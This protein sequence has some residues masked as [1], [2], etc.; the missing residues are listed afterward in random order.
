MRQTLLIS[1]Y[2]IALVILL[3]PGLIYRGTAKLYKWALDPLFSCYSQLTSTKPSRE[4]EKSAKREG[5]LWKLSGK[6]IP[7]FK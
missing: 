1:I 5:E 2:K 3:G 7:S 4:V 6:E